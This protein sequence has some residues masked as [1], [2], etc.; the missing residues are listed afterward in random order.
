MVSTPLRIGIAGY[1]VVGQR[2]RTFIDK[3]S[4]MQTVAVCDKKFAGRGHLKDGTPFYAT[5]QELLAEE[6]L[7]ILFVCL[8]NDVAPQATIAGLQHGLHVFCEKPPGK[9]VQDVLNVMAAEQLQPHLKLMYGFNHRYHHAVKMAK[10]VIDNQELGGVIDI[11]GVYGKSKIISYESDWRTKRAV[12]G[13]GILLDQGIH[14]LD[15]MRYF[16]GEFKVLASQVS[17]EFWHHDV[18]DNAYAM[19]RSTTGVMAM[20][21]SSATQWRHRF[22]LDITLERGAITLSG[23]LSGSR[24]YGEE[25][26]TIVEAGANDRGDP[27]ERMIKYTE[28]P[29]WASEIQEFA[30]VITSNEPVS[31]GSSWDALQ[32]MSLV[33]SIYCSDPAWRQKFKLTPPDYSHPAYQKPQHV[34]LPQPT[35][36]SQPLTN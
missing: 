9:N 32:T 10:E 20:I 3:R 26:I 34:P 12:A 30:R 13:G 28:D 19:L 33:Y 1:G 18:E 25:R 31:S 22:H 17:N 5:Y 29:S 6:K 36:S 11:K 14:M 16:C 15:L 8:T 2:R 21:H 24:S 23:I 27:Q 35:R 7:D 4:D